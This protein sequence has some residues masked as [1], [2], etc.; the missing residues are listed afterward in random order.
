MSENCITVPFHFDPAVL[1]YLENLFNIKSDSV[2]LQKS[3][4]YPF[5]IVCLSRIKYKSKKTNSSSFSSFIEGNIVIKEWDY[6]HY[7]DNITPAAM[8]KVNN[9]IYKL[10][11][12]EACY[13]IMIAHVY[14]GIPRDTCIRNYIY[15]IGYTDNELSYSALRKYYQRNWISKEKELIENLQFSMSEI[16]DKKCT[17]SVQKGYK[18]CTDI[19]A[20][21]VPMGFRY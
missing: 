13:R 3:F 7:G 9:L 8:I 20:E 4:F 1:R 21:I 5:F 16:D 6:S 12:R 17:K 15:E 11:I 18:K 14:S 10:I 19:F 2:D